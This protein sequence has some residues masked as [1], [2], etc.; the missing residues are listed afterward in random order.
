MSHSVKKLFSAGDLE[1]ITNAVREAESKTSGE[2]VPFIVD[3]SDSYE[4]AEWRCGALFG[5]IV[6]IAAIYIQRFTMVWVGL[7]IATVCLGVLAA[8]GFGMAAA[9]FLPPVRR[10]AAGHGLMERRVAQRAT[11]A[12]VSEEVFK[13]RDRTGILLFVSLFE[14]KVLVLGDSGINAKVAKSDWES[15]VQS[16]TRGISDGK[17]VEALV[18]GIRLSGELLGREGVRIRPDDTDELPD[19]LRM[20]DK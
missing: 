13:T 18:E 1:R 9:R 8:F 5:L 20:S 2:I 12:F 14:H 17:Y 15:L 16:M 4:V 19:T 10:L 7:D 11:E 3:H 6:M